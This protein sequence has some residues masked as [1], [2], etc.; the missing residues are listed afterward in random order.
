MM[1]VWRLGRRWRARALVVG[2]QRF[3]PAFLEV[4]VK[5]ERVCN[6]ILYVAL[7][8]GLIAALFLEIYVI[9]QSVPDFCV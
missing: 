4:R 6:L 5:I 9:F 8:M 2:R 1:G 7:G 3:A